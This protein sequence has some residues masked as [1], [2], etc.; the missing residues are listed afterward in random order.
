MIDA[1]VVAALAPVVKEVLPLVI[2]EL[3]KQRLVLR[4]QTDDVEITVAIDRAVNDY[5]KQK[6]IGK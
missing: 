5:L 2:Q 3:R 1:A 4:E 6:G